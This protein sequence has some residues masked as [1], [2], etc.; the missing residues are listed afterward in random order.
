MSKTRMGKRVASLLLSLVMMLSLLPTTVYAEGADTGDT[1]DEIV[2]Q[3]TTSGDNTEG[4]GE[5]EPTGEG[6]DGSANVTEGEDGAA[7]NDA[8]VEET[9]AP[10]NA[11]GVDAVA[12]AESSGDEAYVA[13]I[14]EMQYT[15]LQA[16]F[17]AANT[18]DTVT[19][20]RD[21]TLTEQVNITKAL[22]GL[23][24]D[25]NNKTI[26]CATT[27]DPLQ[28]GGS[29]LYFGNAS[30]KLYCT[31]IKIR[32]LTMTGTAR[33]AIFL[34]GGTTT[35]FT[36]VNISGNYYIAVN[37]YGTHGATM[38]NCNIS[39]STKGT[40]KY[41]SG[42]WSNVSSANPLTL[43]SSTVDVIAINTY[44]TDNKLEPK[45]FVMDGSAAEI[46]TWDDGSVSGNKKLCVSTT[47]TGTYTIKEHDETTSTW[48]EVKDYVAEVNGKNY[49][50]LAAAINAANAGDT[51]TLLADV[52]TAATI[53]VAAGK[54]ITLDLN[55]KTLTGNVTGTGAA[56]ISVASGAKLAVMDSVGSGKVD[57]PNTNTNAI[58]NKGTLT[59]K[60]GNFV[61]GYSALRVLG[62]STT[63]INGGTFSS[64]GAHYGMYYWANGTALTVTVNGGTF[65]DSVSTTMENG[66]VTLSV[67][68][69]SFANDLS[70]YCPDG[71]GTTL[72]AGT[73]M[74]VYGEVGAPAGY[75][76]DESGNVTISDEA[77]LF[78]FAKQVNEKGKTFAGKTVTL[79]DDITLTKPWTPVGV[80]TTISFQG[81]FDGNGHT[82]SGVDVDGVY[83]EYG[84][85]FFKL[86]ISA[87]IKNVTFNNADVT[88]IYSN[89]VG[90]VAGYSYGSST[91]ENVHVTNSTVY[92]F[93]KVGGMVGMASDGGAT[94]TF[95]NCSVSNTTIHGG[96]NVAGFLG[97]VMGKCNITGSYL[98]DNSVII[99]ENS[100]GFGKITEL[101]TTIACTN[102][103][104]TCPGVGT[105]IKGKYLPNNG[106]YW[107]AYSDLYNHYGASSHDCALA[108]GNKLANSEVTHDAPVKIGDVLYSDL[109]AA[110]A[111]AEA[112]QTVTLL[113]DIN[114]PDVTYTI[115]NSVTIDL[116]G[117]T[118]K[119]SGYDGVFQIDGENATL[120][121]KGD[122]NV[123]AVEKSGSAG[124]Y[125]MAIWVCERTASVTI[126]GGSFSQEIEHTDDKQFDMIYTSAGKITINGGHFESVTPKWTINCKDTAYKNGTAS[127]VVNGGTFVGIDPRNCETEGP[128][129]SFVG[130]GVGVNN[131]NGTFTATP[132][133]V[134]QRIAAD[135]SSVKAYGDLAK[136]IEEAQDGQ[137]VTLLA[138]TT[139]DV[140]INKNITLDLG[141]KTLTNTNTG[142]ATLTIAKGATATVK[143]GSVVGGS[144]YY[145]IQNNGTAT[146]EG[147][148]AT[149]GNTGSSMLDNWGTLTITSGTYTGGLDTVKSEEGSVLTINGG[150]FISDYAPKYNISGVVMAYGT[151]TINGG[152][153]IQNSTT[154][155]SR[156]IVT[157]IMEGYTSITYVK[158]GSF[159]SKGG[160]IFHGIGKAT[161]DNFEVSGGTFN[162]SISDGYC[163]DGFI[164]TK[165]ADGTYGV[166]EGQYV[167]EI[168]SK[169]YETLADAIRLAAKGKT[170][171]LLCDV[172]E[173]VTIAAN[174]ELT[175]DL[176]GHTLNGGTGTAKA[177]L[178]NLGTITI[179]DSS[180][181]QTGT[182]KR[183]DKGIVGETSY[184]VIRNQG[185]MTIESGT[186]TNNS[187]YA[188]ANST[189]SMIGSSLIC[190]GDCDGV[191]T[192]TIKG[193]TFTQKNFIAIKNGA[194]GVLHVTGGTITSHH[195]AI[196]NWFKADI[197]GGEIKGQLWT[198]AYK[199]GES[200]GETKIGGN[201]KF[202]GEIVMDIY[203]S[204]APTL[205]INGGNLDVTSWRITSAAANAGAKPAISGGT[206]T[207]AVPEDY[208]AAGYI[209]TK[210]EDGFYGVKGPYVAKIGSEGFATLQ[211]AINAASRK[212]TVTMLADTRE[213]VTINNA[214]TLD[215]N[216]HTLN[217]GTVK[218][219]PTLK[220]DTA[221]VTVMDSSEAKTG[222]IM[223]EDTAENSGVSSHYVIDIQGRNALLT[224]NSGNV[225][226]NSGNTEGKGASLVRVGDD[227]NMEVTPFLT[228]TGGTFTQ[229]NFIAIKVD[230]GILNLSGGEVN[231]ANSYAVENWCNA[232]IK[233]G[234][235]NGTVSTW[236]YSKGSETSKLTI[237][238]GTVNGNVAS[239]NYDSAAE[240]Q[241]RVFIEGGEVTGTLGTYTY[242][243]G[244][245]ATDDTSMAT[246]KVSGGTFSS[247]VDKRYCDEGYVPVENDDNTYGVQKQVLAKIGETAYYTMD[248]AFHAVQKDE[249][250]VMQRDYTT[251]AEQYSGNKSFAI[252]LNDKT[253]TYTGTNTNHA[254]FEINYPNV[255]LTVKNGTV[256]SNSMV[257]LI[258][259]VE[260]GTA[261]D[262][263]GLVFEKVTMTANG[264]SG[265]ETNG[266]N[267]N[268]T[269]TLRNSTLNV[270]NGFGI[271]F[272]SSGKLTIDNS[273]INA[274]TM[275]VQ[276]CSGSLSIN[277]GSAITVTGDAVPKTENDGAIQDGAAISIVN[278]TGYKGLGD[279]TVTGGTFT[280]KPGNAAIKAYGWADKTASEWADAG[281]YI[282]VSGGTFS[283][284]VKE[285]YC[286]TGYIPTTN[287]DGT[288]TVKEGVYVAKV[289]N[290]KYETLQAA[291]NAAKGGSTVRLLADVTLTETAVFPAGKTV[292]LNLVGHNITATGTALLINGTTDIQSTGGVGTIE[293]TGNVAVAVGDNASLTV[294]SGVL[295][296]REGAVITG[297]ATG[298]KIEIRGSSTK[299]IATDNAVIAGNGSKRDGKSNTILVKGGTF[300][301]GIVT[302]GYI[303]C[304]IYA[305]WNDNVSVSGGTF[306]ITNGAGIVA[307]AGTVKVTGGTF[308]CGDG[309]AK[310]WV[311]D[312]KNKVPC[313][314]LVFDKAANY[315]AL[316]ESSQILVSGGSFSTDP[317][318]NGATLAAGY[319][320]TQTDGM[321]KVAKADPAAE[322][323]GVKYDTLQAAINAAQATNG[324]A[325][326]T[327]LKN[328]N[329]SSYYEVKG[330]NPVTID[331]AG[332]NITGSGISGL[333]YVTAKGDLTIKGEGTVT[334]VEDNGA[335]M[336]VW[337]RSPIAKVTLEG[338]TYT[339]QITNTNDPHFDLIYVER[340]NVY[341]K[342]GTYNGATPNWTLNCKD[343]TYQSKEANIEVTGGTFKGF[344]PANNTAEGK[345]TSF[346]AAGYIPKANG[347]GSYTVVKGTYVA[348]YN[349]TKYESLQAAIDAAS[350]RNGGQTEVKLLCDLTITETVVFAKEFS[351]GSVLLNLGGHTL[352]GEDCR[353][354]QINKGNL[355]LE[356]G[357]VTSTGIVDSSSVI[358]IGS[359]EATYNGATP[360]LYMQKDAKVVAPD[361]YGVTIFGSATRGEKLK[362]MSNAEIIATGPSPAIS[363][364]GGANYNTDD[365][366][367]GWKAEEIIIGENA[368]ISATN[369][370]AIYHPECGTMNI[371]GGT[372]IGKG[373][374]QM[375]SGTLTISGSPKIEALGK[376]DHETGAAGPIYDVAAIS[377]VNRSYPGGAPVVTIKGTP[378]VTANE[379][380]VIHAYTWSNNAESE[381]AE[382]GDNINVSGGTYNKQFNEAYLAADCTL[383]TNSEGGYTVEQKKVAEYN[384]TQ[385]TSLA[386]AILD[387]NKAG[388]TVKLLEDVTLTNSL[389]IGGTAAVTL[390][391]NKKTLTLNGA[392]IYTQGS[393]TVTINNGTIKRTDVP[394][395]GS[396]NNFAIQVMSGSSLI[397]GGGT[398]STYKVTLESTYGIYNVGGTL[399][400]RY[401]TITTDGWSIAVSDSAS[402]TGKVY[403]GRG[404]GGNTK[405]VITS[406]SGNVLG[407]MVNSKPNVTIDY[408]TLTS[409]GTTW[410]AG[411]IYWASEGTL[412]ITGGIFNASSAGG[413]T[414][415]AVYQKNGTVKIS[416]TTTKLLGSNALVVKSGEGS[417]GT[418]VTEL[419]GGT[420]S[421][422]PDEAWVVEG[423]EIHDTADGL[424]KVEGPYVVEVTFEDGTV[425]KFDSWSK[426]FYSAEAQEHN[427]TV[428]LL[429][430]IETTSKVTTW[431]TV[432]VDFNGHTLTVNS[433]GVA[434]ITALTKGTAANVTLMDS[435]GNGGMVTTGVY[436]V[437]VKGTGATLTV[438]SGNYNCETT[439]V[440]VENGTAY[441]KGGT[442][443]TEDTDKSYLLNCIDAAF[444]AGT[445]K[446]EVT[447]G[448]FYGFDPSANP[449]GEGTTYVKTGYVSTNNGDGT[450]TVEEA[451]YVIKVTSCIEGTDQTVATPTGGGMY[452]EGEKVTVATNAVAGFKFLGWYD[453]AA[454]LDTHMTYEHTVTGDCTLIAKYTAVSGGTF[455][456]EVNA[457]KFTVDEKTKMRYV[458]MRINAATE[459][460]V[461]YTG[462]DKFLYW[463]NGSNNVVSTEAKITL[464]AVGNFK[465]TAVVESTELGSDY[466]YVIFKNAFVKGQSLSA[467]YYTSS[468]T[469]VFPSTPVYV[470]RTF[471]YWGTEVNGEI[472]EATQAVISGLIKGGAKTVIIAPVYESNG[473]YTVTV[474]YVDAEGNPLKDALTIS[475]IGTGL[476]EY[477]TAD[478]KIDELIFSHWEIGGKNVGTNKT[479]AALSRTDGDVVDLT[480]V[481]VTEG[482]VTTPENVLA[483]AATGA[484]IE[485]GKYKL[486][487]T[488]NYSVDENAT[489]KKG[490]F[491]FSNKDV[492][493]EI[494]TIDNTSLVGLDW[495]GDIEQS[496]ARNGVIPT[497]VET[498]RIYA[499]AYIT[500][501]DGTVIYS[502]IVNATYSEIVKK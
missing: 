277:A 174:K 193:G 45:I 128:G 471:K 292:H 97:L 495:D 468:D 467:D 107:S 38:T 168:G 423:K 85:G 347:D 361:S 299:L 215:L 116:N 79:A 153:F 113:A 207:S 110:I 125:A 62:G 367:S 3:A 264:Y 21:I 57:A 496:G 363:G 493:E 95:R 54:D 132:N 219:T 176:N 455:R 166:K 260:G 103:G 342:G 100:Q 494:F 146:L 202:T 61:G 502:D 483:I 289:D 235:V 458:D 167:A 118:V 90:I 270:P 492:A 160:A 327:L 489:I 44:T 92:A 112:G 465:L 177:A 258:P 159:T 10:V 427:A 399:T 49:E 155:G 459:V 439:A 204:V 413:S 28:S 197:T 296:G 488:A 13:K 104:K 378:T 430:D 448:T 189:G 80:S 345:G 144:S 478:E 414:A 243:N 351:A 87:T 362:V 63:I 281:K 77:G 212:A 165:N 82:I 461:E 76:E 301:G 72:D 2:G 429:T 275:G 248:E 318:A 268:D 185:K 218:G 129:T 498:T 47:S 173:N 242:S 96:Y 415:A 190:N 121:I 249:T 120:V 32:D 230:R 239:V 149:A 422:K 14:G 138:D 41:I 245:V 278:R 406:E 247:P 154:T 15:T 183:D 130:E 175:L 7:T 449:E 216:G 486:T 206:F 31:G 240:K 17:D 321:Y 491:L 238:G 463:I 89:V 421:T 384:G 39:N 497:S 447:G 276:V 294:Y 500:L 22:N 12:N 410:D 84:Y 349:G 161:S 131:E 91:F 450:F 198:D 391:L 75:V 252:D 323:N 81:T 94:T 364:N 441:I 50:T 398:G 229:N 386:Q 357:T 200:V 143:N 162:K 484:T 374:I 325:T 324:G 217:G 117:K 142:K 263:S 479:Y 224:F 346:V 145:T 257:G 400:V 119:G 208:C 227:S 348:E 396:A 273:Q 375:C 225:R 330:E 431:A 69:G 46:H 259:S 329:T 291:I 241:A 317:A 244:L 27:T 156:V 158:G 304:G 387:A 432:T 482:T 231:S 53:T 56:A 442:F 412:T 71:F 83:Q 335:A 339:Q 499:R 210:N 336:A 409:N 473:T 274:K 26:T 309:T 8:V 101:D 74:Y 359:N 284:A 29:A 140:A 383:V 205:E 440:Q 480:A 392:Q 164:P 133:M 456:L 453:G 485:G 337:V 194:L 365:R 405:T 462:N 307:R 108:N 420:Y 255:T 16:A 171:T 135:G 419:S 267:T 360:M 350:H 358:R 302:D 254:A 295:K 353:A 192:L 402:K 356:N 352:T 5:P 256:A 443:Q 501:A 332:Y 23:T 269:V 73:N 293:S 454:L 250:I 385:Y 169:K 370:Y 37:L 147:V 234:I 59:I 316:T 203:D 251:G 220:I 282:D 472:V 55:G 279:V 371:Q 311:G 33:F 290:V 424:H 151:T 466:A 416:G 51:V 266:N 407:T 122:G 195:S 305:P 474:N 469:I 237:S 172:T 283:S 111:A 52:E 377:V 417:T 88:G 446:M 380:E 136:A 105:V 236:V 211:A 300:E 388:G 150:K 78:W 426:A 152:E 344:D 179:K 319:V 137:T 308:N 393:A 253:W 452:C 287:S 60:S 433:S 368:V 126:N 223:R 389:G 271:Y 182:I 403:I 67:K 19:L 11:E 24:L 209:P 306:N 43:N 115:K 326:I 221:R 191:P 470:G 163:A 233:G 6:E 222:T 408:G 48:V 123:V 481:Y 1:T 354:L 226:N 25:G 114:T 418:M 298:A 288:H 312:S 148:T 188:K 186:V 428:K 86:L 58:E 64:S 401:A 18:G 437:T 285:E 280:A 184:Y 181:A 170:V 435:V 68:G 35:E 34:C 70:A 379:G 320:A 261:Y 66:K 214:M 487:F 109:E 65:N 445:A 30:D 381:W 4:T 141:G 476:M 232:N 286:G 369:N 314:A 40:D 464:V 425:H 124:K 196:Q 333:F 451:K 201:A 490:G 228:I 334:A 338:G 355:Y 315:P 457:S 444:K 303:A 411:V 310:G 395:S 331:L 404:M 178:T 382:A 42:I 340:G 272:P 372:I 373:G 438:E 134:A 139:E 397:L 262:N 390:N 297:T 36:N 477:V 106:Y 434:A 213:N 98:A 20:L 187:G 99:D 102:G 366:T 460:V 322:I 180:A 328:I 376:A 341:V 313:A 475:G 127:I 265:I 436:G 394:T 246:I 343:E 9:I 93:G 157:G 199:E